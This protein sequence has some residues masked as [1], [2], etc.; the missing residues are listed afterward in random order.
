VST[1]AHILKDSAPTT[2]TNHIQQNQTNIQQMQ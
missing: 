2:A 1:G